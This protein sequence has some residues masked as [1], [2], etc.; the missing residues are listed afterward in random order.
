ML[1]PLTAIFLGNLTETVGK[2]PW[3]ERLLQIWQTRVGEEARETHCS[4][5][6]I[7]AEKMLLDGNVADATPQA[8]FLGYKFPETKI[9]MG[10]R[11]FVITSEL[12][13]KSESGY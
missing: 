9:P 2:W 12:H 4:P 5:S 11:P 3:Q 1:L 7:L 6:V 13:L 10:L 8:N